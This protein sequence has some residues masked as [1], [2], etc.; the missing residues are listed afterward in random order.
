M[1]LKQKGQVADV[2][3]FSQLTVTMNWTDAA[4]FDLVA[5]Y[6]DFNGKHGLVYFGE[7]GDLNTFPFIELS[8]DAGVGDTGGDNEE[9]IRISKLDGMKYIWLLCW[10]YAKIQEG[11]PAKFSDSDLSLSII[12]EKG[13]S[14]EVTFDA[15]LTG[16]VALIATIDNTKAKGSR[17][18]NTSKAGTIDGL[19]SIRQLLD[20]IEQ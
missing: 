16:N 1:E 7:L 20:I 13:D 19:T 5:L 6:E 9:I 3:E 18:I 10:N 14:H 11:N 2:D 8:G 17:V 4:D 15:D 12:G